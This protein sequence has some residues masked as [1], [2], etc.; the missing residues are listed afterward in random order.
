MCVCVCVCVCARTRTCALSHRRLF[1]ILW[2][3]AHQAPLSM[4]FPRQEYWSG[5][6]FP[7]PGDLPDLGIKPV[8]P[9]SPTLAGRFF[10]TAPSKPQPLLNLSGRNVKSASYSTPSP[11]GCQNIFL[12]NKSESHSSLLYS[13]YNPDSMVRKSMCLT[14]RILLVTFKRIQQILPYPLLCP[15]YTIRAMVPHCS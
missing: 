8:S 7:S 12:K 11:Q 13:K 3:V 1:V 5:L 9:V 4:G 6:L 2:T 14:M 15:H 10:P